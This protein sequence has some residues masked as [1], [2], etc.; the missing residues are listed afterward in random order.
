[1]GLSGNA[2][3]HFPGQYVVFMAVGRKPNGD[4]FRY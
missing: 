2:V 1:M 4:H 3:K